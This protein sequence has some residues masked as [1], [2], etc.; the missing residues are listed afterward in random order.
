MAPARSSIKWK[1]LLSSVARKRK[2]N[3][4]KRSPDYRIEAMLVS[5]VKK[6]KP[7]IQL[8]EERTSHESFKARDDHV[9]YVYV[10]ANN[11][12]CVRDDSQEYSWG[13]SNGDW[14]LK[15]QESE[16]FLNLNSFFNEVR[17]PPPVDR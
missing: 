13:S 7:K 14:N 5:T 4:N 8:P 6:R 1:R 3:M 16:D 17:S 12:N 9:T 15:R 2:V 11:G 10:N